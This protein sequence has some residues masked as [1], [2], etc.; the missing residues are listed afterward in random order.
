MLEV[1]LSEMGKNSL[2]EI[3]DT[4]GWAIKEYVS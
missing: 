3:G 4:R 2:Y 1:D